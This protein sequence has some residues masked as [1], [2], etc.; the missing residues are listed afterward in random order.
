MY[1]T[2]KPQKC[3]A[4]CLTAISWAIYGPMG[5][6]L[7]RE[8]THRHGKDLARPVSMETNV[9]PWQPGKRVFGGVFGTD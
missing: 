3:H 5:T 9:L 4:L 7:G 8:V 6:K 1:L 2:A